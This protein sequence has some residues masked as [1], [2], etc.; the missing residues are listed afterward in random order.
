MNKI[1]RQNFTINKVG[2][3]FT[4]QIDNYVFDPEEGATI[5][6]VLKFEARAD[7]MFV[8][9]INFLSTE[10]IQQGFRLQCEFPFRSV[11]LNEYFIYVDGEETLKEVN[12][13]MI[14]GVE[15]TM[16]MAFNYFLNLR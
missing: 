13:F 16:I 6:P 5:T 14:D 7:K 2:N 1:K 10:V 3:Y 9:S 12:Y 11:F 8:S 4:I 15:F